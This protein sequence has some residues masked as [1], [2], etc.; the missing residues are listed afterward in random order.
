MGR[1]ID[2]KKAYNKCNCYRKNPRKGND[3]ENLVCF[4]PGI[5]GT[6]TREQCGKCKDIDILITSKN[7]QRH[8][9]KF[10]E[11]GAV[12]KVCLSGEQGQTTED[13][14]KCIEKEAHK[15]I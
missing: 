2:E 8:F 12:T 11:L 6:L 5:I 7:L 4:S 3:P 10:K 13:F 9:E 15:Q 1:T 14:Y